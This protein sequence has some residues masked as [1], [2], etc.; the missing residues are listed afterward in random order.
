GRRR[1][2]RRRRQ[3]GHRH[4]PG[5]RRLAHHPQGRR[6]AAVA[7]DVAAPHAAVH[8]PG[9]RRAWHPHRLAAGGRPARGC[10]RCGGSWHSH[11]FAA[12]RHGGPDAHLRARR[13]C[14]L[15]GGRPGQ[16]RRRSR[17]RGRHAWHTA[18]TAPRR[19]A[20]GAAGDSHRRGAGGQLR[21]AGRAAPGLRGVPWP[22][23]AAANAR[24]RLK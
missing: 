11:G 6:W 4:H 9:R 19:A 16:R 18:R 21:R 20:A 23:R 22:G 5:H 15:R 3:R 24:H 17:R 12:A 8:H 10:P 2:L 14:G 1:P 7:D 13:L